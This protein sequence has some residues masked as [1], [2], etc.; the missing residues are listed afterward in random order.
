MAFGMSEPLIGVVEHL[1]G[2]AEEAEIQPAPGNVVGTITLGD[3]RVRLVH[4]ALALGSVAR[5]PAGRGPFELR[6]GRCQ[7]PAALLSAGTGTLKPRLGFGQ[8][9]GLDAEPAVRGAGLDEQEVVCL[10]VTA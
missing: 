1:N 9:P 6:S 2:Q 7:F 8:P 5:R 3:R 4:Q 10:A